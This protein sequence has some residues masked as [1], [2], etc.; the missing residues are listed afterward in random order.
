MLLGMASSFPQPEPVDYLEL[1]DVPDVDDIISVTE[2]PVAST[3]SSRSRSI[4]RLS[5]QV[6][7]DLHRRLKLLAM[8]D[9]ETMNS[10]V[11]RI[12]RQ[13]LNQRE[14]DLQASRPKHLV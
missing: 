10:M 5:L 1:Y 12:L 13:Y 3:E 14:A 2:P 11:V 7:S 4:R 8:E 6:S 9:E